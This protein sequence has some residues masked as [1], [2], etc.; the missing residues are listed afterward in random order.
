V[1]AAELDLLGATV[2]SIQHREVRFV[3]G[4]KS[5]ETLRLRSA[6]DVFLEVGELVDLDHTRQS[7]E[8]VEVEAPGLLWASAKEQLEQLRPAASWRAF[9]VV[10]SFLG[11][12]NYS[13]FEFEDRLAARLSTALGLPYAPSHSLSELTRI[14]TLRAHAVGEGCVVGLRI[15]DSPLHRRAYKQVSHAGTLHPPLA[16]GMS[17]IA[18]IDRG[19]FVADPFCG[20][21]TLPIEAWLLEPTSN[22]FASDLDE[23]R[24]GEAS[25]NARAAGAKIEVIRSDAGAGLPAREMHRVITNPPWGVAVAARGSLEGDGALCDGLTRLLRPAGRLVVLVDEMEDTLLGAFDRA[26][27]R[28]QLRMRVSLFGRQPSVLVLAEAPEGRTPLA[29]D[30]PRGVALA[31]RWREA[32]S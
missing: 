3:L 23:A 4:P 31:A 7:L 27:L 6:D 16:A 24:V 30:A 29:L 28:P 10:A 8:R 2:T 11:K 25:Q 19:M 21:G 18:G 15:F 20:A 32:Q 13:R 17:M 1:V 14:L 26:G 22:V 9:T 5:I 12:R